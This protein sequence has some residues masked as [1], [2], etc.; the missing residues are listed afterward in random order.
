MVRRSDRTSRRTAATTTPVAFLARAHVRNVRGDQVIFYTTARRFTTF[1]NIRNEAATEL[2]VELE[3]Y[4]P[5]FTTPSPKQWTLAGDDGTTALPRRRPTVIGRRCAARE[6]PRRD[7]GVAFATVVNATGQTGRERGSR[8]TSPVAKHG[9]RLRWGSPGG[10]AKRDPSADTR[11]DRARPSRRATLGKRDRRTSVLLAPIST[12]NADCPSLRS[13][14]AAARRRRRQPA[15][16]V[17]S[18]TSPARRFTVAAAPTHWTF[19]TRPQHRRGIASGFFNVSGLTSAI[20]SRSPAPG[21]WLERLHP[22][23]RRPESG[24]ADAAHL[25]QRDDRDVQHGYLLPRR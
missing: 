2:N 1:V 9:D 5:T 8:A 18:S 23:Q 13:R 4:G 25:L 12:A 24:A 7:A 3:F 19:T 10:G 11:A 16:F 20:W 14:D 15:I 22:L 17:R 6:G 21:Q